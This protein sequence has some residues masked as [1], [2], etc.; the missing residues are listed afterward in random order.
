MHKEID[1]HDSSLLSGVPGMGKDAHAE[2]NLSWEKKLFKPEYYSDLLRNTTY[3]QV[4]VFLGNSTS[5]RSTENL[6]YSY[7]IP[8]GSGWT[9][10]DIPDSKDVILMKSSGP[11]M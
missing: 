9:S 11:L 2:R 10:A 5:M 6:K 7:T 3:Y 8:E 4:Q 1:P